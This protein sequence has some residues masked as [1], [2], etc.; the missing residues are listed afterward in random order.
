MQNN[1]TLLISQTHTS[2]QGPEITT[3]YQY[4]AMIFI[5]TNKTISKSSVQCLQCI[6]Q[7]S[8]H[9]HFQ[10]SPGSSDECILSNRRPS[11]LRPS[12]YR[13][14]TYYIL[15]ITTMKKLNNEYTL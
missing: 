10:S 6:R 7:S 5:N 12:Q 2:L 4:H 11:A 1:S 13:L 9:S 14:S 15:Y 8:W 3:D